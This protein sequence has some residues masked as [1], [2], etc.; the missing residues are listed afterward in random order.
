MTRHTSATT[1]GS[2]PTPRPLRV[3]EQA[4]RDFL[5]CSRPEQLKVRGA[6]GRPFPSERVV[7]LKTCRTGKLYRDQVGD[8]LRLL[9]QLEDDALY[10]QRILDRKDFCRIADHFDS[11]VH[12]SGITVTEFL[13]KHTT[14]ENGNGHDH[15]GEHETAA[16]S[17]PVPTEALAPAPGGDGATLTHAHTGLLRSLSDFVQESLCDAIKP[18]QELVREDVTHLRQDVEDHDQWIDVIDARL[19][20]LAEQADR[21]AHDHDALKADQQGL[22]QRVDELHGQIIPLAASF[23]PTVS[24][25]TCGLSDLQGQVATTTVQ[26][27]ASIVGLDARMDDLH[28]TVDQRVAEIADSC[29]RSVASTDAALGQLRVDLDERLGSLTQTLEPLAARASQV[30]AHRVALAGL[31]YRVEQELMPA[32][33]SLTTAIV[34]LERLVKNQSDALQHVKDDLNNL[35]REIDGRRWTARLARLAGSLRGLVNRSGR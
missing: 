22:S 18:A 12:P 24:R 21:M 2:T 3:T 16:P 11:R 23:E 17:P 7:K 1:N 34:N 28:R 9:L 26:L 29:A 35:R 20:G 13:M 33:D 25:L 4:E 32:I 14:H 10:I 31:S 6:L 30:P 5:R 27:E 15:E 8:S 19:G